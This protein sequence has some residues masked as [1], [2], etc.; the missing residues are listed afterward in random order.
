M[1]VVVSTESGINLTASR[2]IVT[3]SLGY[4]QEYHAA[5]FSPALPDSTIEAL[6]TMSMGVLN[7]VSTADQCLSIHNAT[8]IFAHGLPTALS[9]QRNR[10]LN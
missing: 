1:Q 8:K 3:A 4:L 7:K 9:S 5:L 2:V 6:G 10:N